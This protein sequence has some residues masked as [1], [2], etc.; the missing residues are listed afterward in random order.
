[1]SRHFDP[2]LFRFLTELKANNDRAWFQANRERY[3]RDVREPLTQFVLDFG[4]PLRKI[5]RRFLADPRPVGGS[6]FRIHRDTRFAKDKSPYKTHAAAQFRHAVGKDAHAPCFYL[7]LEPGNVFGGAGIWHPD[8]PATQRIREAIAEK[9]ARW[10]RIL[11]AEPFRRHFALA[12]DSLKRPPRGFDPDHPLAEDLRR[13]D[14]IAVTGFT[15]KQACAS[16]F[17]ER[18]AER[19]RAAAPLVRFVTEALDLDW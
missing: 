18:Y 17:L 13:K 11:G 4:P 6:I 7:H 1:M 8:G 15:D 16:G 2:A 10:K 3:E 12:G 9:P 14:F 5:S 19:C